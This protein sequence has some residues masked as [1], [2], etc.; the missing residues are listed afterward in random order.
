MK[1]Y[2]IGCFLSLAILLLVQWGFEQMWNQSFQINVST[3]FGK[4]NIITN[5]IQIAFVSIALSF[6]ITMTWFY[7]KYCNNSI[8]KRLLLYAPIY[9][10]FILVT[11]SV[12][13]GLIHTINE[14]YLGVNRSVSH[15]FIDLISHPLE[16]FVFAIYVILFQFKYVALTVFLFLF[17][18]L[19]LLKTKQ[20]DQ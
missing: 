2:I 4:P 9:C 15:F 5:S 1:K 19:E 17:G 16:A 12:I 7:K 10:F 14:T 20:A 6:S 8:L 11:A 13:C 18:L 3:L